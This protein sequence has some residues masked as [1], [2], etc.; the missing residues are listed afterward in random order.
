MIK[1]KENHHEHFSFAAVEVED[2]NR[3]MDSLFSDFVMQSFNKGISTA[4]FP[5]SL[6]ST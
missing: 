1:I 5:D 3:E 4:R 6:K 2:V